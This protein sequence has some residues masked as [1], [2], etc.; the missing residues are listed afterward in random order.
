[1]GLPNIIGRQRIS[2]SYYYTDVLRVMEVRVA[3]LFALQEKNAKKDFI[4]ISHP[5]SD[6]PQ[7]TLI[8]FWGGND[9]RT[10]VLHN[11]C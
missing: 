10:R 4:G 8:F 5:V 2:F 6:P 3:N 1:M 7:I 11:G 9:C